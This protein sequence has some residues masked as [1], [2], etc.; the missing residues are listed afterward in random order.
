[1][2]LLVIGLGDCG[3][4][5]AGCFSDLNKKARAERR[6]QIITGAYAV[7]N[8]RDSLLSLVKNEYKDL[9]TIYVNHRFDSSNRS[10]LAGAEMMRIEGGRILTAIKPSDFYDT[11]AIVFI[12][13]T[14]GRFGSG[15]ITVLMQQLR[16]RHIGKPLY[17]I[18]IMPFEAETSDQE[19]I[20]NTALCLKSLQKVTDAVF[21]VDN[22][23][24]RLAGHL[25][26]P[27]DKS[28]LNTIN[29]E[30]V[31]PYYDLLSATETL[32][33]KFAG[34]RN[35]GI[36]D[37]LQTL[38]GWTTIGTGKAAFPISRTLFKSLSNFQ[39]KG[40]ET[41]K[42]ME[43]LSLALGRLSIDI[44]LEDTG[45]ALYLLSI[46]AQGANLDMVKVLGN[47][48]REV[49]DNAIIRGGDFYGARDHALVT[50][51]LSELNY[52]EI[53]K[54]YFDRAVAKTEPPAKTSS[55]ISHKKTV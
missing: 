12:T 53:V 13:G 29:S 4:R 20:Y 44:K 46:P 17:A 1:M 28:E 41:Q 5:L 49:T 34:A 7:N 26:S 51:I 22:E 15:G 32:D 52:I 10:A 39:E 24:Y 43:A 37:M 18:A 30:I 8:E 6:I 35:I 9:Q 21:L 25:A 45:R 31:M 14:S 38:S 42:A 48:L 16:D 33:P 23:K 40:S 19:A 2:K 47:H 55:T 50:L 11:D 36:G 3:S 54:K 27:Q